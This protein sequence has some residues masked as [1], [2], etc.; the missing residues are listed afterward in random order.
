[1]NCPFSLLFFT[2]VAL[3]QMVLFEEIPVKLPPNSYQVQA[4]AGDIFEVFCSW[5]EITNIDIYVFTD[6]QKI[7]YTFDNSIY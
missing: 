2:A 7:I 3:S 5:D 1:M 6:D 4:K